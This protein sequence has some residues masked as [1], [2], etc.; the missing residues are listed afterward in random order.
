[1]KFGEL[2]KVLPKSCRIRVLVYGKD[3]MIPKG[4][5]FNYAES[6]EWDENEVSFVEPS[7]LNVVMVK[8]YP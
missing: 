4:V 1:M 2:R 8:V 3:E 5:Y 6:T 7:D